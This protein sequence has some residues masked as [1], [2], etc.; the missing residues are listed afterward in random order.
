[1]NLINK[2]KTNPEKTRSLIANEWVTINSILYQRS[3]YLINDSFKRLG[4][5]THPNFSEDTQ[6]LRNILQD[7]TKYTSEDKEW[8]HQS[9]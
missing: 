3:P 2:W 1:M 4:I 7:A 5:A 8:K 9:Q 6:E